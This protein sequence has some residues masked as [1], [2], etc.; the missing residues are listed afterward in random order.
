MSLSKWKE[1]AQSKA[2]V[3]KAKNQLYNQITAEKIKKKD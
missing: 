2:K 1:L 3:G